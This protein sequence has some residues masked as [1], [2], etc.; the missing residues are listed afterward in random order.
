[1]KIKNAVLHQN[2]SIPG[3]MAPNMYINPDKIPNIKFQW[4]DAVGLV[5]KFKDKG[6]KE[7]EGFFPQATV[8]AVEVEPGTLWEDKKA[9]TL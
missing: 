3:V 7:R 4:Q 6:G 8:S 2:V 5:W 1:M 9:K